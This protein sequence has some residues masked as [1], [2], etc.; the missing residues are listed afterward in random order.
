MANGNHGV[1]EGLGEALGFSEKK[2]SPEQ[3]KALEQHKKQDTK[4]P[5]DPDGGGGYIHPKGSPNIFPKPPEKA[6]KKQIKTST[7]RPDLIRMDKT[8]TNTNNE[9]NVLDNYNTP[10]EEFPDHMKDYGGG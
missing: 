10:V 5:F 1:G 2:L 7:P 9:L 8:I 6:P 4:I 3:L